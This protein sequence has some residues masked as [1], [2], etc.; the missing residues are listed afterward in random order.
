LNLLASRV[1]KL[2]QLISFGSLP[3]MVLHVIFGHLARGYA[4]ETLPGFL[5]KDLEV[6][7]P[8]ADLVLQEVEVNK[9]APLFWR[10]IGYHSAWDLSSDSWKATRENR[11]RNDRTGEERALNL[12][13]NMSRD[14]G[15]DTEGTPD[16]I[17]GRV[18][19]HLSKAAKTGFMIASDMSLAE[20]RFQ[21]KLRGLDIKG[22]RQTLVQRLG[23]A[24]EVEE[25]VEEDD[26]LDIDSMEE[27][28]ETLSVAELRQE[29]KKFK[30]LLATG[31]KARD[32]FFGAQ[33]KGEGKE[34]A[35]EEEGGEKGSI[36]PL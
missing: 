26:F 34:A 5:T 15:L 33:K 36:D 11:A 1:T 21:L 12:F 27:I 14:F 2:N 17:A 28:Y 32:K 35:M 29:L 4:N 9:E 6:E 19:A 25:D 18:R 24:M 20:L 7:I 23:A 30:R 3:V 10:L 16:E 31:A 8:D 22:D 13:K